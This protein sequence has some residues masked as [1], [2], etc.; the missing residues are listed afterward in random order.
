MFYYILWLWAGTAF[1]LF[2]DKIYVT[3]RENIPKKG[4]ILLLCN[5]PNSFFEACI[6]SCFQPRVLHYL[7]RGDMFDKK[8]LRPILKYTYQIPIYRMKDGFEKLRNNKSTFS[9]SF[10]VL[11]EGK[12]ILM[13]PEASTLYVPWL[14]PLQKGAAR[15]AIGAFEEREVEDLCIIPAGIYYRDALVSRNSVSLNFGQAIYLKDWYNNLENVDDKLSKL[16]AEIENRMSKLIPPFNVNSDINSITVVQDIMESEN[17]NWGSFFAYDGNYF[18]RTMY[19]ILDVIHSEKLLKVKN[20]DQ[21][22]S[23]IKELGLN[24]I[25]IHKDTKIELAGK[26]LITF[27]LALPALISYG[28]LFYGI[29][30]WIQK[31]IR[32]KEFYSPVRIA[33]T[34]VCHLVLSLVYFFVINYFYS[35]FI[36]LGWVLVSTISIYFYASW[37]GLS[38]MWNYSLHPFK[39]KFDSFRLKI[40][41]L[42]S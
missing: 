18:N 32:S 35:A 2:F 19:K 22:K 5:H 1:R 37:I 21:F 15:L 39:A 26:T 11:K 27:L 10:D 9:K 7:V 23:C 13:F 12:V 24:N 36:A 25:K 28:F 20:D 38:R 40:V 17:D 4:P 34:M 14:R 6:I 33:V 29:K 42:I 31:K 3:G 16:N 30:K 8:W 41:A